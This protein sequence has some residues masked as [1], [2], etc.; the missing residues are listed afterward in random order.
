[1]DNCISLIYEIR[2]RINV[3]PFLYT[4]NN[5]FFAVEKDNNQINNVILCYRKGSYFISLH[6][7]Y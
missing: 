4:F 7:F 6:Q 1:M 5:Y 2:D 3:Y